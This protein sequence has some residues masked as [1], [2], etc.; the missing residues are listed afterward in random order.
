VSDEARKGQRIVL[1]IVA[2]L[3]VPNVVIALVSSAPL[4]SGGP[5]RSSGFRVAISVV[6]SF[7]LWRGYSW[8]R[9]Y[10]AFSLGLSALLAT[11]SGLLA[12]LAGSWLGVMLLLAPVYAWGAWALWSSPNVDAYIEHRERER[13]P[14]MSFGS[15]A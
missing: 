1:V 9:S 5:L 6:I 3:L 15:G 4:F 14:D 7:L 8:A 12:L 13:N 11:L 2:A 10:M